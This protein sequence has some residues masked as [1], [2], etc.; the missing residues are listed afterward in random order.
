ML[1]VLFFAQIATALA[2]S[3]RHMACGILPRVAVLL[4]AAGGLFAADSPNP[5]LVLQVSTETAPAGGWAQIKVFSTTPKLIAS[6]SIAMDFDPTVFGD[7]ASVAVFS[8]TGD[9]MGYA[10][11][12]GSHVD[13]QFASPSG[14]IGQ[15]PGLPVFTV[16]IPVLASA[17]PGTVASITL[18]PTGSAWK[19]Q[20]G[21][22][23]AVTVNPGKFTAGGNLSV[24]SV[25]PGGGLAAVGTTLQ[26]SGTGFDAATTVSIDG[27]SVS[28]VHFISP[29]RIDVTLG[30]ATEMTGKHVRVQNSSGAA[31]EYFSAFSSAP[32]NPP[33]IPGVHIM[34]PLCSYTTAHIGNT[35]L[36]QP[37]VTVGIA[38]LN[39][40]PTSADILFQGKGIGAPGTLFAQT[41]TIPA[42]NLYF[43]KG[44]ALVNQPGA[45]QSF[46]SIRASVPV[47]MLGYRARPFGP[48]GI[49]PP[50]P[51]SATADPA[52]VQPPAQLPLAPATAS[53]SWQI[54]TAV[55]APATINVA[56][57]LRFTVTVSDSA[58]SWLKVTP[59]A[60]PSPTLT[61]TP[62]LSSVNPGTYSGT[63]TV[64]PVLPASLSSLAVQ[65]TTVNVSLTVSVQPL[66]IASGDCCGFFVPVAGGPPTGP[67][68]VTITS[69]G[70]PAAFKVTP[71]VNSGGNWLKVT[72]AGGTTPTTLTVSADPTGLGAGTYSGQISVEGPANT[73]TIGAGLMIFAR[74]QAATTAKAALASAGASKAS[75][76]VTPSSASISLQPGEYGYLRFNVESGGVPVFFQFEGSTT[77][78]ALWLNY[79]TVVSP[80]RQPVTPATVEVGVA[81]WDLMPG[82]YYGKI[83]FS[84]VDGGVTVP[85]STVTI[86][87]LLTVTATPSYPPVMSAIV[88]GA[89]L[90]PAAISPGEIITIF[91]T[92]IGPPPTGLV[93]D[94]TG[95]VAAS[96]GGTQVL[97]NGV[98]APLLYAS[99]GQLNVI[100]PYEVGTS[101]TATIQVESNGVESAAWGVPVVPSAPAIF[102][103]DATGLGRAAVGNADYSVN[104]PLNPAAR[105]TY[106]S[107]YATGEGQTSPPGVT[108]SVIGSDLKIPVLRVTATIGGVDAPVQYDG[109]A[110][111]S[112]AGLL[113]VNVLVP[114][115]VTPGPAVPVSITIGGVKSQDGVTIA[116]K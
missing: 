40:N 19:D 25:T 102:T 110:G 105:G 101:G 111:N 99:A 65:P 115:G 62:D 54:G 92:G 55:P 100:V 44:N 8:A 37:T 91:G 26:I 47:R 21:N 80:S 69:N 73:L 104:D 76:T 74:P 24:A 79:F 50:S 32:S 49:F 88:N 107:I 53:W 72:P 106:V 109:S 90:T 12:K 11:V 70:N 63:V 10:N 68:T 97:I 78:A 77:D 67:I 6:G 9:G 46:L 36:E 28:S 95:R 3:V 35:F 75:L 39:P 41:M 71:S 52:T 29:L 45:V 43:L 56:G 30:G 89:S 98:A 22:Q 14:A 1:E 94:A 51:V 7:I 93:L 85:G 27:V 64:T 57:N 5:N 83:T 38:L 20:Q 42:G 66:L 114:Q 15:V 16:T 82:P 108:G 86:P 34:L 87:V 18:D 31:A 17:K 116:V 58:K 33:E 59:A 84:A 48:A 113:Q 112:V 81:A 23:Y 96:L 103:L 60:G 4:L 13:A 61:L 2:V